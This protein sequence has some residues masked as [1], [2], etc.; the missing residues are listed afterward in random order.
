[1]AKQI[2]YSSAVTL[3]PTGYTNTGTYNFTIDTS[4]TNRRI[5]NAY[6]NADNT[7]SSARLTLASN[8][9]STRT[10]T[11]YLEFDKSA[12]SNI[13]SNATINSVAANVRYYVNST[14]YVSAISI[15]LHTN[16]TAKGSAVTTR[17]TSSAKYAITAGSWTLSELSNIRL[18][19]SATHNAGTNPAYLY[20]YGADVTINYTVNETIYEVNV[21]NNS[22]ATVSPTYFSGANENCVIT[23]SGI[24]D[25]SEIEVR[26]NNVDVT[27]SL[28]EGGGGGNTAS[29][30]TVNGASYG[31]TLDGQYYK[32]QNAGRNG[33]AA[34]C[35]LNMEI[36]TPAILTVYYVNYAEA[37]YDYGI[38]GAV[39]TALSTTTGSSASETCTWRGNNNSDN[40]EDERSLTINIPSG[41]HFIDF[42]FSKD[43]Y[44]EDGNDAFWFRY[45]LSG[46]GGG[47][48]GTFTYTISNISADHTIVVNDGNVTKYTVNAS[49]TYTGATVSPATQQ[50][51]EGRSASV[52]IDVDH[53]YEI[54]V[55]DNGTVVQVS[56]PQDSTTVAFATDSYIETASTYSSLYSNSYSPTNGENS[57]SASTTYC[58]PYA[59]TG[60]NAESRLVYSFDCSSIPRNAIIES[61]TCNVKGR[62]GSTTYLT[63]R[64]AQLYCGDTAKGSQ[65]TNFTTSESVQT[66]SN[67]G[68]WTRDE[69]DDIRVAMIVRRGT[70]N[71]TTNTDFRFHG[72]TLLV[73]YS[74]P[75]SYQLANVQSA[76]T[77]T[78]EEAPYYNITATSTYNGATAT[79]QSKGYATSDV[80]IAISVANLYEIV[81]KD[82]G[83]DVTSSVTGNN[84]SYTYT[85]S[86][87][88]TAHTV[89]IEEAP[90]STISTS[91][92]Y[93]GATISANPTKVYN[94]R[95]STIT[96]SVSNLYEVKI[97]DGNTDITNSFTGSNGTYRYTLSNVQTNHTITV[98]EAP[99]STVTINNS[100][101]NATVTASPT[102][103]YAGQSTVITIQVTSSDEITISD[104]GVNVSA[105]LVQAGT[106]TYTYTIN[107][108]NENHTITVVESN[109]YTL[110]ATSN[111]NLVTITPATV[112]VIE[113]RNQTFTLEGD[114]SVELEHDI[115]LTDNG[116][117]VTSQ[118]TAMPGE[119]G[120]TTS[121]LGTFD[122]EMSD[123]VGIYN[124]YTSTN[125]EGNSVAQAQ[126]STAATRSSF[127][128]ATG[129][130]STLLVVYNI[131][132]GTMPDGTILTNVSCSA[133]CSFAYTGQGYS[134]ITLQLYAASVPK[135]EAVEYDPNNT[136]VNVINV[137]GGSGWTSSELSQAKIVIYGVRNNTNSNNEES[138]QRDNIN[139]HGADL[140][141]TYSY[142]AGYTYTVN[143]VQSAHT[144]VVTEIPATY[145]TV[146]AS[147]TYTGA[148]I[149][150]ATKQVRQNRNTT[151]DITT[152]Y[153]YKIVVKDNGVDVTDDLVGSDTAYTYTITAVTSAHTVVVEEAPTYIVSAVSEYTG[154]T[155]SPSSQSVY[156]SQS[157]TVEIEVGNVNNI[158]VMDNDADVTDQLVFTEGGPTSSVTSYLG[159][160]DE[161]RSEYVDVYSSSTAVYSADRAVGHS[162]EEG[163]ASSTSGD[164]RSAFYPATGE[165]STIKIV[166]NIPAGTLPQGAVV[167]NVSCTVACSRAYAGSGYSY[168]SVQLYAGD[169]P[170]G[171]EVEFSTPQSYAI[172]VDVDGGSQWTQTELNNIKIVIYGVRNSTNSNN[173][174]SGKRDN[175]S[176]HGANLT[177]TYGDG[178]SFN[179]YT[180]TATNIRERHDIVISE[181]QQYTVNASST[182]AGVTVTPT[183]TTVNA[184]QNVILTLTGDIDEIVV[185]DNGIDVTTQ[186]VMNGTTAATYTISNITTGHT[187]VVQEPSSESDYI[188]VNDQFKKVLGI[189]RKTNGTWTLIAREVF[190]QHVSNNVVMFGG[191]IVYQTLG[192][193]SKSNN[194]I[195]ISI[196]DNALASGKYKL[197]YEDSTR[198]PLTNVDK[199]TEF[200]IQ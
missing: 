120:S 11:M 138:G 12:V 108:V 110:T 198:T 166:Y 196:N 102:K 86:N 83:T 59:N 14:T 20:L 185:L 130:G 137:D 116:V 90:Y 54:V 92:S 200:T 33:S 136:S 182:Y 5:S 18:Y 76:H 80:N 88:Q 91:S 55:K 19:I 58:R 168:T 167:T 42:K 151:F 25:K 101:A 189:Y 104:N 47:Q 69:L 106:G 6:N 178:T 17:T 105:N 147:S 9:S 124:N 45:E 112:E 162:A 85:I 158:T 48:S 107:N 119:T 129:E 34:L 144:I 175:I 179:G 126:A 181:I 35:R 191:E 145:Y 37:T 63:T 8:R 131:P 75:C 30:G 180:Y 51:I 49:S 96:V 2:N 28:V 139:I 15:Q 170:K 7:S 74:V 165:G 161:D 64:Y 82:N 183:A 1:M 103:V 163:I 68:T 39:D 149:S 115:T 113:G 118:M 67:S 41:S 141:L 152:D 62:V 21:T 70:S 187:V 125:A 164:T 98:E 123:Y 111:Y 155:V 84:G 194:T 133:A 66:I 176:I 190:E 135:G 150:P 31:F 197:V 10:S 72:A 24:Q 143:N 56:E 4:N 173:D 109:R 192:E 188:K 177:I 184:R 159:S 99:Y 148:T 94:G 32:S 3:T 13:P 128:P 27:N 186:L 127:Y 172:A 97:K 171:E 89:T 87:V 65:S 81:V 174:N 134:L 169:T 157:A 29:I 50:V 52:D 43:N 153:G 16:T 160:I 36:V 142:P 122:S 140:V 193:V 154:A 38:I 77:I 195:S 44:S 121:H 23:F 60:A 100:Y 93:A 156:R 73:T 26:D 95:S 132:A 146:N 22:V 40:S 46:Q 199:I 117:D 71:T 53:L 114:E 61:V 79:V 57:N 78:V